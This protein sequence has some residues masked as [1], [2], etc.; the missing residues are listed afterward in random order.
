MTAIPR[1][2]YRLQFN[3][4]F[5]FDDAAAIVPYLRDLGISHVYASPFLKARGGSTHGYDIVDHNAFNPELGGEAGFLRMSDALRAAGLGMILDFVPNHMGVGLADNAWW[6]D[7]LEWGPKSPHARAFDIAWDALPHRRQPG[8]LLPI[9][10]KPYGEALRDGELTLKYDAATGSFAVWYFDHKLPVSPPGYS[11]ILRQIV[12]TAGAAEADAGRALRA[13]ADSQHGPHAPD[14][15]EAPSFKER[16]AAIPGGEAI[17]ARGLTAYSADTP[18]G[19]AALHRLLERQHYRLAFWRVAFSAINYRRFFD[20]NDLAGL[21]MEDPATFRASHALVAR[22]IAEDR[23]QGLRLD[24]IDG[25]RDP[26]QYTR[27]LH[28]LARQLGKPDLYIIV[29]KIL[30]GDETLPRFPGVAGTTGYEWLNAIM[31]LMLDGDGLPRLTH[32]WHEI[33]EQHQPFHQVVDDAKGVVLTTML[34][35]EFTVL[36]GA[37]A[38]IAAGHFSTRDYTQD[39]LRAALDLYVREFP[40]YRTYV[41]GTGPSPHDRTIIEQTIARARKRWR[42][43]DPDIFEFLRGAVTLDLAQDASYSAPRVRAFAF[44]LQ[45]FTGPLMAKALED[46]AF[47]RDQRL[48]ALN[49]VGGSPD[50]RP[51]DTDDFHALMQRRQKTTPHGL[52]A[53]AT[54]DTKRGEDT[55]MRILML[56]ELAPAWTEAVAHWRDINAVAVTARDGRRMP[57]AAHEYMLYQ[58][59]LGTWPLSTPLDDRYRDRIAAYARKAAREGKQETSWTNPDAEYEQSLD[60]FV[61]RILSP[62]HAAFIASMSAFASRAARHG[63]AASLSQLVLKA[64]LPGVP[65]FYQGTELWDFSLVDPDNRRPVDFA[66]RRALFDD[67]AATSAWDSE[68]FK[69]H[70][71][72]RLLTLRN[73]F[74]DTFRFG[75]YQPVPLVDDRYVAF[76]R[77]YRQHQVLVIVTRRFSRQQTSPET[78]IP[79]GT[80]VPRYNVLRNDELTRERSLTLA[81]ILH[82]DPAVV[83]SSAPLFA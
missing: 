13:L 20:V 71:T 59:L 58:T 4:R 31:R 80:K 26:M 51:L 45:Q 42:G 5:T 54:H 3:S 21:R 17:I 28:Q 61:R 7:V 22:L 82:N 25:L 53:T 2:T 79:R 73:K 50:A 1:D 64:T 23:L 32:L 8:V 33:S 62:D 57:S 68:A 14:R 12:T 47:Y 11:E 44:R 10:G 27:R 19:L 6:L 30:E 16:L 48:I 9:L 81:E 39:R 55:R 36:T 78:V 70:V 74:P 65:D 34:A 49:E 66:A 77:L 35:S 41:T 76:T 43:P 83:L 56:A 38:R 69:F 15:R 52:T 67:D 75:T 60:A 46:T 63:A 29:E 40:V 18:H 24:H 37:L 72:R